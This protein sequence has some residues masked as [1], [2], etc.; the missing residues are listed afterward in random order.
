M[1][2]FERINS[3]FT[4]AYKNREMD[5][6]NFL[7]LLKTE[8]TK[9]TKNPGDESI[10]AVIKSM[11]KKAEDSSS[12]SQFELTILKSYLPKQLDTVELKNVITDFITSNKFESI[13]DMGKV[14]G[15]LKEH[16]SGQYDGKSASIMIKDILATDPLEK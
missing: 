10:V 13:K 12:L 5:K 15:L 9:N 3:D 14:M 16:F 1:I 2:L 8:I 4:A 7:G 11:M 6:K